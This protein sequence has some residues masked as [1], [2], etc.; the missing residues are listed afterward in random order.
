MNIF[1]NRCLLFFITRFLKRNDITME[2]EEVGCCIARLK[3]SQVLRDVVAAL[4]KSP[5]ITVSNTTSANG[6]ATEEKE[7]KNISNENETLS[8]LR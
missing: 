2:W 1:L 5:S 4:K 8:T 6:E 3:T 7:L